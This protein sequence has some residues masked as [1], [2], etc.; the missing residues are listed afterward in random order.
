MAA[1][2]PRVELSALRFKVSFFINVGDILG[3]ERSKAGT[4]SQ[5]GQST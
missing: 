5:P 3:F 4:F 1:P 2:R